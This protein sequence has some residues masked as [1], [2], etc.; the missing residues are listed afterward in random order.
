MVSMYLQNVPNAQSDLS[1]GSQDFCSLELGIWLQHIMSGLTLTK[2]HTRARQ[3]QR[4]TDQRPREHRPLFYGSRGTWQREGSHKPSQALGQL[5][6]R[7]SAPGA[8]IKQVGAGCALPGSHVCRAHSK[9]CVRPAEEAKT[10]PP[11]THRARG[12]SGTQA[13]PPQ[14]ARGKRCQHRANPSLALLPCTH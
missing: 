12:R 9:I 2:L 8:A 6:L 10:R 4:A 13:Q 7:K 14:A 11:S 1:L 5:R 3:G